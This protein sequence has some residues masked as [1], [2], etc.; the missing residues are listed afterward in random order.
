MLWSL[1][2]LFMVFFYQVSGFFLPVS[3]SYIDAEFL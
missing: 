1:N 3:V 2:I